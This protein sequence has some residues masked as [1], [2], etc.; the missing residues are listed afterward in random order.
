MNSG[1]PAIYQYFHLILNPSN[2][3][4][5]KSPPDPSSTRNAKGSLQFIVIYLRPYELYRPR[6]SLPGGFWLP[7]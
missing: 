7:R 4:L 1:V 5:S 3:Y 6:S 2:D